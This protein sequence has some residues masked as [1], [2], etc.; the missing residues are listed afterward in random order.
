MATTLDR[1]VEPGEIVQALRS[2]GVTQ[3]DV[4]AATHVSDRAVRAWR[5]GGIRAE[6]YERLQDLRDIIVILSDSLTARG[7]GQWLRARNRVLG[8]ARPI[9]LLA[10]GRVEEVGRA[11][12]S[13]VDGDYV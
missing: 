5:T 4:A 9:D 11:A 6:S 3:R 12:Q 8:G 13:F 10:D 1:A 2:F 7:V